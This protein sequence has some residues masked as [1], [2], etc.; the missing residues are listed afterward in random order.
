MNYENLPISALL[1]GPLLHTP[2][3]WVVMCFSA[4][5]LLLAVTLEVS[6]V[7]PWRGFLN[8]TGFCVVWI[9]FLFAVF[10]SAGRPSFVASWRKGILIAIIASAPIT[11][12]LWYRW[13]TR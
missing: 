11:I 13:L 12:T 3:G 6:G 8:A 4:L 9:F 2:Q 7:D 1:K 10:I 5:Y